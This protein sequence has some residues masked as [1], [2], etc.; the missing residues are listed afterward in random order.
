MIDL[1]IDRDTPLTQGQFYDHP[2]RTPEMAMNLLTGIPV[3]TCNGVDNVTAFIPRGAIKIQYSNVYGGSDYTYRIGTKWYSYVTDTNKTRADY[4]ID[5]WVENLSNRFDGTFHAPTPNADGFQ[6]VNIT[7]TGSAGDKFAPSQ[8]TSPK[9]NIPIF[10][11]EQD[12]YKSSTSNVNNG[13]VDLIKKI[14][15]RFVAQ[16]F[17]VTKKYN[18]QSN[19]YPVK[20]IMPRFKIESYEYNYHPDSVTLDPIVTSLV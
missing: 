3:N 20:N 11:F 7:L 10:I 17:C 14:G 8:A 6:I 2:Y 18:Q 12:I 15:F 19:S 9:D 16:E 4:K 13:T 1:D 5:N